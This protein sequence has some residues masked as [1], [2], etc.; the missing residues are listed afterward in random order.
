MVRFNKKL[1]YNYGLIIHFFSVPPLTLIITPS[2]SLI[3]GQ[4]YSLSCELMG[5]E[6]L[7]V[8]ATSIR[9]DRI[10]PTFQNG[11]HRTATLSF[12]PL[13]RDDEGQYMCTTNIMSPYTTRSLTEMET[14]SFTV[15]RK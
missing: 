8:T 9:W 12:N 13:S 14:T 3:E 1:V 10:A 6:T 15:I 5:G 4:T 11:V 7:D 2:G